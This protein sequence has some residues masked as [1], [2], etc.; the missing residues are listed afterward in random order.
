MTNEQFLQL[1]TD[2]IAAV[3]KCLDVAEVKYN[4][5]HLDVS[6]HGVPVEMMP[7]WSTVEELS[8][9]TLYRSARVPEK[10]WGLVMFSK[11]FTP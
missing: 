10:A 9:S 4:P 8:P 2:I 5:K 1:E 6:V 3:R 11:N 7:E